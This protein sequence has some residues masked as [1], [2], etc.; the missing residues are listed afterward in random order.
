MTTPCGPIQPD[1]ARYV[2]ELQDE[3]KRFEGYQY[4]ALGAGSILAVAW[5][6]FSTSGTWPTTPSGLAFDVGGDRTR[7]A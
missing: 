4:I 7:A 3:G 2:S 5:A 6:C 1:E